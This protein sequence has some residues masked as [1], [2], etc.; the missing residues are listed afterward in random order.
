LKLTDSHADMVFGPLETIAQAEAVDDAPSTPGPREPVAAAVREGW[1]AVRDWWN[2]ARLGAVGKF[3]LLLVAVFLIVTNAGWLLPVGLLLGIVYLTYRLIWTLVVGTGDRS[4]E[5]NRQQNIPDR[6]DAA[7]DGHQWR[8][9]PVSQRRRQQMQEFLGRRPLRDRIGELTGS[10]LMSAFVAAVLGLV[11]M[12]VGGQPMRGPLYIW[13]PFYIWL[14]VVATVG[15]WAVL[16]PAKIWEGREDAVTGPSRSPRGEQVL[17]RFTMLVLGLAVGWLAFGLGTALM[18]DLSKGESTLPS[19]FGDDWSKGMFDG[20]G[21]PLLPAYLAYFAGI[22][23]VLRWWRQADP[24]RRTR[25]SLWDT[26]VAAGWAWV[27][28]LIWPFP[29]PWGFMLAMTIS[30]AVQLSAPW[31]SPSHRTE[32]QKAMEDV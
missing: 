6:P 27:L 30:L 31:F 1:C 20:Y 10:M 23:V 15:A 9:R 17:R 22:Y 29:Q 11:I 13:D 21:Q 14:V 2:H 24:M 19:L 5:R 8:C 16:I 28:Q 32:I 26:A 25:L 12:V 4:A 7:R 3:L 18:V